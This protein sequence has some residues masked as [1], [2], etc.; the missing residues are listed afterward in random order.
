MRIRIS[1]VSIIA[2]CLF[3]PSVQ[4]AVVQRVLTRLTVSGAS[5]LV[6]GKTAR[7]TATASF[8]DGSS[9]VVTPVW[10]SSNTGIVAVNGSGLMTGKKAGKAQITASF[11]AAEVTKTATLSVTVTKVLQSV[12]VSGTAFVLLNGKTTLAATAKFNDGTTA[13]V[14]P[15]WTSASTA[16]AVISSSGQVTGKKVGSTTVKASYT[17]AGVTKA[18]SL[19]VTVVK[20]MPK[21]VALSGNASVFVGK[22]LPIT[23][24]A[25]YTDGSSATVKGTWTSSAPTVAAVSA[26]GVVTGKK[27]G[28]VT[29]TF[30]Y[31]ESGKTV[32]ATKKVTVQKQPK[33]LTVAGAASVFAGQKI[34]LTAT[35]VYTDG[36]KGA[37]TPQWKSS[38]T[39]IA[40]VT[41]AGVIT[42]KK[43]G[44]VTITATYTYNQATKTATKKITVQKQLKSLTVAGTSSVAAGKKITLTATA[45]YT[46]GS[47]STVKPQ[48]QSQDTK[49]ATITTGGVVTGKKAGSVLITATYTYSKVTKTVTK[50]ITVK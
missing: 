5:S 13:K 16:I 15:K 23:A 36:S 11:T 2:L 9:E 34:T 37:V 49:I 28:A 47:K 48:W 7:L 26:G 40:T 17:Y 43:A 38:N 39:G 30:Q 4:G 24:K 18:G 29:I 3:L 20:K 6:S 14:A 12:T 22:T 19:K 32:T 27:A 44:S 45:A 41:A 50:R 21:S 31:T 42:G 8:D 1:A 33:S 10:T 35:A 46:D 25:A